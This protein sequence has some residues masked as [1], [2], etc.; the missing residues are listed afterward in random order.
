MTNNST[1][2]GYTYYSGENFSSAN[3]ERSKRNCMELSRLRLNP[4]LDDLDYLAF[5]FRGA[6]IKKWCAEIDDSDLVVVDVGGRIQPYR[7][8]LET[9]TARYI[10][11]DLSLEGLVDVVAD[12]ECLPFEDGSVDVIFCNDSLQYFQHPVKAIGEMHRVLRPGGR[13]ILSSRSSFPEHH[14]EHWRFLPLGMR[15]LTNAFSKVD[16]EPEGNSVVGLAITLND[17]MHR[18]V[19]GY[20]WNRLAQSTSIPLLNVLGVLGSRLWKKHTRGTGGYSLLAIK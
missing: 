9:R 2:P 14:D 4:K 7:S 16:I 17:L 13:L 1:S 8:L 11:L 12:A 3:L 10:G 5:K 6:I 18:D 20:R 15:F 19:R